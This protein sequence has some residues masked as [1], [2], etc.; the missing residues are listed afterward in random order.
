MALSMPR[1]GKA[2]K[3]VGHIPSWLTDDNAKALSSAP[4]V[5]EMQLDMACR[6]CKPTPKPNREK[7]EALEAE[8]AALLKKKQAEAQ[9]TE[10]EQA[11]DDAKSSE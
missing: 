6:H 5:S 9:S 8:A 11:S 1:D 7:N 3:G 2:L 4:C 10:G